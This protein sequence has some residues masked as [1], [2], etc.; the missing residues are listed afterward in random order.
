[1]KVM[2]LVLVGNGCIVVAVGVG[3]DCMDC[4]GGGCWD[5]SEIERVGGLMEDSG[6]SGTG[7]DRVLV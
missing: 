1:M 6:I 4:A 3:A 5:E 2:L 7:G